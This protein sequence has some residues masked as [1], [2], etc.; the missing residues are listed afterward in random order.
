MQTSWPASTIPTEN[1]AVVAMASA[2]GG[3]TPTAHVRPP[4]ST[5]QRKRA[6]HTVPVLSAQ[7]VVLSLDQVARPDL[8]EALCEAVRVAQGMRARGACPRQM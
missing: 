3:T 2:P 6:A 7:F 1:I 4:P 8:P 5:R